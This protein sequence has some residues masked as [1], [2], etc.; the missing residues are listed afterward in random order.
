MQLLGFQFLFCQGFGLWLGLAPTPLPAVGRRYFIYHGIPAALLTVL[1]WAFF[2]PKDSGIQPT[3]IGVF[4]VAA[5]GFCL[6]ARAWVRW[7]LFAIAVS[8]AALCLG[9][10]TASTVVAI[11][12]QIQSVLV[13]GFAMSAMWLGHWYLVQPKLPIAELKKLT[14][15]LIALLVFRTLWA[16]FILS[17]LLPEMTR[18]LEVYFFGTTQG[19]F[20][21]MR[22][23]WGI[24]LPLGVSV[25]VWK[26]LQIRSTQSA[27][28]LLY[29]LVL[30]VI[31]GELLSHYLAL[32]HHICL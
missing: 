14:A 21:L 23:L 8:A 31:T 32:F 22:I 18:G 29:V 6:S 17:S 9:T 3:W 15:I 26:T 27:T 7:L 4:A 30:S 5:T 10:L 25:L 19:L 20:V 13:L 28:G 2:F 16:G 12:N 24:F 11:G 1:A